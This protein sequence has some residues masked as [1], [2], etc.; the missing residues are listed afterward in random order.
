VS[1]NKRE[2]EPTTIAGVYRNEN[3]NQATEL[4]SYEREW[5]P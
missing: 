1:Y 4:F 2:F 5:C 3:A